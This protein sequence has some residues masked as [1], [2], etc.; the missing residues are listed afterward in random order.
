MKNIFV[1]AGTLEDLADSITSDC[2]MLDCTDEDSWEYDISY[3]VERIREA[4]GDL[5]D[6]ALTSEEVKQS[7]G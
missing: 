4:A 5:R 2:A 1:D 7:N 6:L 3:Y